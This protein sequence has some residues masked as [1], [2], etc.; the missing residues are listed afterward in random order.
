MFVY[1]YSSRC[2]LLAFENEF[3][4]V[5]QTCIRLHE[6]NCY[7]RNKGMAPWFLTRRSRPV[8][9]LRLSQSTQA[10]ACSLASCQQSSILLATS[11]STP[12]PSTMS[13]YED[14]NHNAVSPGNAVVVFN[15]KMRCCADNMTF[16]RTSTKRGVHELC[17]ACHE[18]LVMEKEGAGGRNTE[19]MQRRMMR[20]IAWQTILW[21]Y[22]PT[23]SS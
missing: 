7:V 1:T 17:R 3:M 15:G 6:G 23:Q 19:A 10:L 20:D 16:S 8:A 11:R 2:F 9:T 12:P 4:R 14:K 22:A 13:I 5:T 18:C 21:L